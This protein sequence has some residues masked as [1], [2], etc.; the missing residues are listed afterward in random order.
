MTEVDKIISTDLVWFSDTGEL[1]VIMRFLSD[2]DRVTITLD[3][4]DLPK[5]IARLTEVWYD[6]SDKVLKLPK[7]RREGLI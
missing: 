6:Y 3:P 5:L 1:R 2:G 7:P 4:D